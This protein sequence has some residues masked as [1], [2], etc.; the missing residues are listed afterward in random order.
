MPTLGGQFKNNRAERKRR[1]E[2]IAQRIF[3]DEVENKAAKNLLRQCLA[4][5]EGDPDGPPLLTV[6]T[7]AK[8]F[9]ER[10]P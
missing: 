3:I 6:I 7:R 5:L 2:E 9:L 8:A 10:H 1:A 4:V